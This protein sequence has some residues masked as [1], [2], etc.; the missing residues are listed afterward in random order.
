MGRY[1]WHH[2]WAGRTRTEGRDGTRARS[3]ARRNIKRQPRFVDAFRDMG[4]DSCENVKCGS[5]SRKGGASGQEQRAR[6]SLAQVLQR[7]SGTGLSR[8]AGALHGSRDVYGAPDVP[9][10]VLGA[11][12]PCSCTCYTRAGGRPHPA[13]ARGA[14]QRPTGCPNRRP[15]KHELPDSRMCV[16]LAMSAWLCM[17]GAR[18][19][20]AWQV[21]PSTVAEPAEH[22]Q[23]G[24]GVTEA[25]R[26]SRPENAGGNTAAWELD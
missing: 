17:A 12:A 19:G 21:P 10:G 4:H 16:S 25:E 1:E 5:L 22:A 11:Q 24:G 23:P 20:R 13:D 9:W 8:H 18:Q 26:D 3:K 6:A 2:W 15:N 7:P 14:E